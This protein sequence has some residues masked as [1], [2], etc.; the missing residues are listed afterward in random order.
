MRP[1]AAMLHSSYLA[2]A[3]ERLRNALGEA[4]LIEAAAVVGNFER[5]TRI[6]DGAGIKHRVVRWRE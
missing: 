6:A 4:A 5:M 1:P 3:R 2:E